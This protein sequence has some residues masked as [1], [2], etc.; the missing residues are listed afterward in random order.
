MSLF[1][2]K[3]QGGRG[4]TQQETHGPSSR[5]F[6]WGAKERPGLGFVSVT[7][8]MSFNLTEFPFLSLQ[9]DVGFTHL[10][11]KGTMEKHETF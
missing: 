9:D 11:H 7:L 3:L 1:H 4:Y 6:H 8:G 10:S 2:S 5:S